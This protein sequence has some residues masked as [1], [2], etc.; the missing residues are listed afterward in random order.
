VTGLPAQEVNRT[1][2]DITPTSELEAVARAICAARSISPDSLYQHNFEGDYPTDDRR[3]Y[4]DAFTGE[5]RVM[6]FHFAWRHS[7]PAAQAALDALRPYREAEIKAAVEQQGIPPAIVEQVLTMGRAE[8][9]A[10]VEQVSEQHIENFTKT[11]RLTRER[12]NLDDVP[13][14]LH[15]L[16]LEGTETILCHTGTSP[17]SG[18][19]AQALTGAW[20]RLHGICAAIRNREPGA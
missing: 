8:W 17:N 11:L 9:G 18:A 3:E 14:A 20:N 7:V 10:T 13:V 15:G 2:T 16:Y 5:P 4:V 12:F 1:M 19:N 6:L